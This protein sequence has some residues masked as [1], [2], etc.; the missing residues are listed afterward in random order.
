MPR[1]FKLTALQPLESDL[2]RQIVEYLRVEQ[3]RGRIGPFCRLNGG[4]AQLK[5]GW[6]SFY[7]LFLFGCSEATAGY[8][9]LHGLYGP[10]SGS[11]GRYFALEVKRPGRIATPAQREFLAAVREAGGV[12]A[13]IWSFA[14]AKSALFG[15]IDVHAVE[16]AREECSL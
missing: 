6:V 9:D 2:Q 10:R 14:D 11:P 8:V 4:K 5:S 12:A 13:T 1:A 15:E 3:A 16:N 7:R